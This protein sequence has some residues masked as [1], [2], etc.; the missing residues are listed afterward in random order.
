MKEWMVTL[1]IGLLVSLPLPGGVVQGQEIGDF[2][3]AEASAGPGPSESL[4]PGEAWPQA[5]S[6]AW[7]DRYNGPGNDD[8]RAAALAVD[9][10]GN[11][12]VTGA[13]TGSGTGYDYATIKYDA[14][15]QPQWV[16]RY[17]GPGSGDDWPSA[18]AVDGQGNVYVTGASIG[19]GTGYDYVT[20]K[21]DAHGNKK[22]VRRYNGP[23]NGDD[24]ANALAVDSQGNVYVTGAST[25]SGTGYDYVTIKYDAHGNKKW[26]RRYNGPGSGD[27]GPNA[28]AVDGQGNVYVTGA[29][30]GG[31]GTL[32][33]HAT[34]KYDAHGARQ[35]VRRYNGP[36]NGD[37]WANALAVDGQGNVY[38]A[39]AS[40]GSGT[41]FDCATIMYDPH[42]NKTWVRRYNGP[43]NGDD[44]AN[45]L[46]VDGQG[47]VYVAGASTGSGTGFDYATLMY[48]PHGNK[49]WV[50][51]YNGPVKD[52]DCP[53]ALAVDGQGNLYVTGA[54]TGSD[55][56]YDYAT[57]KYLP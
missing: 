12:Y 19:S 30:W 28:L 49:K 54:S 16:R 20:I 4:K 38:V 29:S 13:S 26:V 46:A 9:G 52:D 10:Q 15:G 24:W 8:D 42:G 51:R 39:G 40:T 53:K 57:I 7:V 48:D 41:G 45:A 21:Y 1:V 17:N 56:V 23:V 14:H 43:A 11:V 25:G 18:L 44:C 47:N 22:W 50:R 33:D 32:F 6:T 37:D 31:S 3:L 35:W 34:I 36:A 55:K 2:H 5:P 27:D